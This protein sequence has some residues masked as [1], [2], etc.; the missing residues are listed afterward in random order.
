MLT[1]ILLSFLISNC[2]CNPVLP[3]TEFEDSIH[4][5]PIRNSGDFPH[6][7]CVLPWPFGANDV[8]GKIFYN[9]LVFVIYLLM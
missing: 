7:L 8:A 2:L 4:I 3:D 6:N 5:Q 1:L 9:L